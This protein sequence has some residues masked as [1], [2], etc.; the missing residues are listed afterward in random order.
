M[1]KD[2]DDI[3]W[4]YHRGNP[5]SVEAHEATK[6]K[7]QADYLRIIKIIREHAISGLICDEAEQLLNMSHQT[8]SA[9]FSDMKNKGWLFTRGK[10]KTRSDCD[11]DIHFE[12]PN[13]IIQWVDTTDWPIE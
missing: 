13:E 11:A 12:T 5:R 1:S 6:H 3:T 4:N 10:R 7:K 8:C 9:R 2:D